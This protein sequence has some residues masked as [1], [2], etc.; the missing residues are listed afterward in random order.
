MQF[1]NFDADALVDSRIFLKFCKIIK[2]Q[3]CDKRYRL[4]LISDKKRLEEK[5]ERLIRL[6]HKYVLYSLDTKYI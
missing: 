3:L 5:F 6:R 1:T 4:N 2:N